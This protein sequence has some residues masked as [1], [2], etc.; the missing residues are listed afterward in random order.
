M[1]HGLVTI[2]R[3][4]PIAELRGY[5]S[6]A[7]RSGTPDDIQ[8]TIARVATRAA[9]P[10]TSALSDFNAPVGRGRDRQVRPTVSVQRMDLETDATT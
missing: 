9:R 4:V 10:T 6:D 5:W 3:S 1:S 8:R 2:P 7:T